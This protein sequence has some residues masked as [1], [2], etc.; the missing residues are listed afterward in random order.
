[1]QLE[2]LPKTAALPGSFTGEAEGLGGHRAPRTYVTNT[3][4]YTLRTP[5]PRNEFNSTT[6]TTTTCH[7]HSHAARQLLQHMAQALLTGTGCKGGDVVHTGL[8]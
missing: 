3:L 6:A 4:Q 2:L 8:P 5:G 7:C 1:L